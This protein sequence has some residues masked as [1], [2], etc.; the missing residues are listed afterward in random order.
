MVNSNVSL[1]GLYGLHV[2]PVEIGTG[3]GVYDTEFREFIGTSLEIFQASARGHALDCIAKQ[4][5]RCCLKAVHR[6]PIERIKGQDC[7]K[8]RNTHLEG[9]SDVCLKA[10]RRVVA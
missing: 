2:G 7:W 1:S 3:F 8:I 4:G 5:S 6:D 9:F 10:L